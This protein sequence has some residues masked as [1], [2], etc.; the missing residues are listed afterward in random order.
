[1]YSS[2]KGNH[3]L[4]AAAVATLLMASCSTPKN[5]I[6]FQE[7][8]T[9]SKIE[10]SQFLDIKV[11]PEDKLSIVVSTQDPALSALFNLVTTQNSI[12]TSGQGGIIGGNTSGGSGHVSYYTVDPFG[13]INFPVLGK[14]HI[15]GLSR[16]QVAE[17]ITEE[18][19]KSNQVKDPIVTV[20]FANANIAIIGEVGAPGRYGINEDH[21]TIIDA[22]A[23]AGDLKINGQR[24][25]ILVMRDNGNGK[26]E[27]YRV[28]LLNA[29]ELAASP[30]FYMQQG[31]VVYVEPNN[32][33]MRETTPNGN[34]PFTPSF[35]ISLGSVLLTVTSLIITLAK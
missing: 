34:S 14:I 35:W 24:D 12:S 25:N 18:L 13:D 22:I 19:I 7:Q 3:L 1:M 17:K 28:N 15:A 10:A 8:N 33:V 21:V 5:I 30:V 26:Y 9:G 2:M 32:K 31:D 4:A 23:M 6:Y 11:Q 16:Y 29:E 20:E 27:S